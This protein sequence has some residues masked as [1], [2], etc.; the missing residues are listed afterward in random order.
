RRST[1]CDPPHFSLRRVQVRMAPASQP[2][3]YSLRLQPEHGTDRHESEGPV[4]VLAQK[5]RLGLPRHALGAMSLSHKPLLKTRQSVFK[6]GV[7]QH[8]HWA[9]RIETGLEA[10][11]LFWEHTGAGQ[12]LLPEVPVSRHGRHGPCWHELE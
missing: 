11:E 10:K 3:P 9:S 1:R 2:L 12:S 7:H 4:R 5:P 8:R 6:Y